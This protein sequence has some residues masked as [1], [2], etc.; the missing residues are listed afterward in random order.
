MEPAGAALATEKPPETVVGERKQVTVMFVDIVGSMDLAESLDSEY[1]RGL[2]ARFFVIVSEAVE[3]LGGTIDKFTGDGVMAPFGAPVSQED[4]A[5]RA[6]LA[7]LELHGSLAPLAAELA[8]EGV[9]LAIRVGL[10][11]GEVI[12]GEI[13]EQGQMQYA[14][15]G[16]T[17]G[18][19]QRMESLAPPGSTT[20]SASIAG[21][22]RGEFE[23][24]ELGEFA[25]F[26]PL[27]YRV[28]AEALL[29]GEDASETVAAQEALENAR[30]AVE[31][32]G[33]HGELPF[34]E[35][36]RKKLI[37]ASA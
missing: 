36:A 35:R 17:V 19:A 23:L 11:S 1:W 15:I 2:L 4:H 3:G 10:N 30:A 26:R 33:A 7:A 12:V 22:V 29:A 25:V 21:L 13:G 6:C 34:I 16:H 31:A 20:L 27:S 37:P 5:R 24:G 9:E 8:G 28:L 32:T 18:L 14:A